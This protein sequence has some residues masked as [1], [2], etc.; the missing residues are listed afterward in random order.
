MK[1][2]EQMT[3]YERAERERKIYED[4]LRRI[5]NHSA[6]VSGGPFMVKIAGEA[7]AKAGNA[8]SDLAKR[9]QNLGFTAKPS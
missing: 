4:A 3:A 8:P 6:D 2:L 1:P 7:L 5:F 9:L